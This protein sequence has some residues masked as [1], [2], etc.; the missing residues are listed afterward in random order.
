MDLTSQCLLIS[1]KSN[2]EVI[3]NTDP[4]FSQGWPVP[5][6]EATGTNEKTRNFC[7]HKKKKKKSLDI[8]TGTT[9]PE[10]LRSLWSWRYSKPNCAGHCATCSCRLCCGQEI[11]LDNLQWFHPASVG[12]WLWSGTPRGAPAAVDRGPVATLDFFVCEAFNEARSLYNFVYITHSLSVNQIKIY[13]IA[14]R[15]A[16]RRN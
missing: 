10:R 12:L 7:T 2:Q 14:L 5:G 6:Q 8:N 16:R 3:K 11:G 15:V 13:Q 9:C 4:D 1:D